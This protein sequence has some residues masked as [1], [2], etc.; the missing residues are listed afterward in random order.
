[1][2]GEPYKSKNIAL[3]L[4]F[5]GV[6]LIITVFVLAVQFALVYQRPTVPGDLSATIGALI[7]EALYLLAKAV[8]LSVGI[9]A[10]AQLLKYGVEL[11][12]GKQDEQ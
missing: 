5:S 10:A 1:M 7:S 4:I 3:I 11:A 12:K 8:F 2:N 6:L 9:V